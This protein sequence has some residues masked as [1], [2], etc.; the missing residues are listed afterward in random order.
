M[1]DAVS[2]IE[3]G[4]RAFG[5]IRD[6]NRVDKNIKTRSGQSDSHRHKQSHDFSELRIMPVKIKTVMEAQAEKTWNLYQEL[7]QATYCYP[8]SRSK[9]R[10]S[11]SIRIPAKHDQGHSNGKDIKKGRGYRRHKK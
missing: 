3:P 8:D 6:Q 10:I 4:H 2:I 11:A 1:H 7:H 9:N 5:L